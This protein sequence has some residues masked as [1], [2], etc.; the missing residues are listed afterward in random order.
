M[1]GRPY[2]R[3]A[4]KV[5]GMKKFNAKLLLFGEYGLMYGAKAL[6]IPYSR[7]SGSFEFSRGEQTEKI[8]LSQLEIERYISYFDHHNLNERMNFSLDLDEIRSDLQK[9]L[10]FDSDIPLQYGVGSS[11]ALCAAVYDCYGHYHQDFEEVRRNRNLL[12]V[13]KHDFAEMESYFHGKSSGFDPLV[14]FIN[15]PV[16]LE[17][18]SILLPKPNLNPADFSV[19]LIDTG[20][21]SSTS[22]LVRLFVDKMKDADFENRFKETFLIANDGA[23][24]AF[25]DGNTKLLFHHL[26]QLS[27]FESVFL[28]EMIPEDYRVLVKELLKNGMPVKL[29]GSGGGGYLLAFVPKKEQLPKEVKSLKVF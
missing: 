3:W 5:E 16:L 2:W 23:I 21:G 8:K 25:L 27:A 11:G 7:F 26:E 24:E 15:Q 13:L 4:D 12:T 20:V 17:G 6:A 22:P 28:P 19:F 14:S 9:G 1:V 10:Y 29:L 18:D